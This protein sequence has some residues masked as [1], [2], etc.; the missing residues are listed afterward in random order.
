MSHSSPNLIDIPSP[1]IQSENEISQGSLLSKLKEIIGKD[2]DSLRISIP[3]FL[4]HPESNLP[5]LSRLHNIEK[6]M[7]ISNDK[8]ERFTDM[9]SAYLAQLKNG[10]VKSKKPLNPVLGEIYKTVFVDNALKSKN[11]VHVVAEQVSHHPPV[12]VF[13]CFTEDG[14]TVATTLFD[15][16][17][18]FTGLHFSLKND[19]KAHVQRS[20]FI[21]GNETLEN[22]YCI[23]PDAIVTGIMSGSFQLEWTNQ[24]T[25]WSPELGLKAIIKFEN[26]WFS[27]T[28]VEGWIFRISDVVEP[29]ISTSKESL[30][31]L[32]KSLKTV[33][34]D[35]PGLNELRPEASDILFSIW[36]SHHDTIMAT[37]IDKSVT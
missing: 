7:K 20:V 14:K 1:N 8:V 12:S 15:T 16:K 33:K 3:M 4:I 32:A 27:K 30:K 9:L 36:G 18:S 19:S 6:L 5:F 23:F 29:S 13:T 10:L 37:T 35:G 25:F 24:F 17:A 31:S 34:I 11:K 2:I 22:Y 21:D 28:K 26:S